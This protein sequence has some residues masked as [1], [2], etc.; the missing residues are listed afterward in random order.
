[1]SSVLLQRSSHIPQSSSFPPESAN[2][3]RKSKEELY[4]SSFEEISENG[5][6]ADEIIQQYKKTSVA[7][8]KAYPPVDKSDSEWIKLLVNL[9]QSSEYKDN[10][11][12][13]ISEYIQKRLIVNE[14]CHLCLMHLENEKFP[15]TCKLIELK[16]RGGLTKANSNVIKVVKTANK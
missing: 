6:I 4:T 11:L 14:S 7:V 10:V 16:N 1:M 15:D 2:N 5:S 12:T 8:D 3:K 9:D 13:Y